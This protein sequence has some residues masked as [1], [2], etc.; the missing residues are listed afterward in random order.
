M[1]VG[2]VGVLVV[3]LL[4]QGAA[5][6]TVRPAGS[7]HSV[8]IDRSAGAARGRAANRGGEAHHPASQAGYPR[9][10][11]EPSRKTDGWSRC[12]SPSRTRAPP[13]PG[14]PRSPRVVLPRSG[15]DGWGR[16]TATVRWAAR[17]RSSPVGSF[18][19]TAFPGSRAVMG[20]RC[21][22]YCAAMTLP[23]GAGRTACLLCPR[24]SDR[25][26][27]RAGGAPRCRPDGRGSPSRS[28]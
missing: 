3:C 4:W 5:Q 27:W 12:A 15:P 25:P 14:L 20:S 23:A 28:P 8:R 17:S 26:S 16:W 13:K 7:A 2:G 10:Q 24:Q 18:C 9:P 21:G 11:G 19:T 6:R 22:C 1:Q